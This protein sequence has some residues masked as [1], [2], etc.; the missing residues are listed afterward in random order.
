MAV[1]TDRGYNAFSLH[2][3]S[4]K[5][6]SRFDELCSEGGYEFQEDAALT[7][8]NDVEFEFEMEGDQRR[9]LG[10]GATAKVPYLIYLRCSALLFLFPLYQFIRQ[11]FPQ[12]GSWELE[13]NDWRAYLSW[14]KER[15]CV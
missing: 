7:V 13:T 6:R 5:Q 11:V 10:V 8:D 1:N 3:S 14:L 9:V 12:I 15:S 4:E 2:F